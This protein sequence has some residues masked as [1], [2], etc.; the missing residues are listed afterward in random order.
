MQAE[1]QHRQHAIIGQVNPDL[2][3]G[4]LAHLPSGRFAANDAWLTTAH[5]PEPGGPTTGHNPLPT[6]TTT[7]E[8]ADAAWV[9]EYLG[10]DLLA[11]VRRRVVSWTLCLPRIPS[12]QVKRHVR[13]RDTPQPALGLGQ[14]VLELSIHTTPSGA[15]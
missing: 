2:I 13:T 5:Q 12:G 6:P 8:E 7:P 15:I 14:W 1:A 3:A 4:P 9:V 10:G 11:A